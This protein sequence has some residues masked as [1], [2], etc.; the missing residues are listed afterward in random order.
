MVLKPGS[1][2]ALFALLVSATLGSSA[3]AETQHHTATGCQKWSAGGT[4][5]TK[6]YGEVYNLSTSN[7]LDLAC[8]IRQMT[9]FLPTDAVV[10][11]YDGSASAYVYCN[12]WCR[13]D[14]S[15]ESIQEGDWTGTESQVGYYDLTYDANFVS[16]YASGPCMF[17][18]TLPLKTTNPS[19]ILGY[20]FTSDD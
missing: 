7:A 19:A 17:D 12:L 15:N 16:E 3:V 13:D 6:N 18:C 2:G 20:R 5:V 9:G 8:P 4:I 11:V 10:A 14:A 1:I